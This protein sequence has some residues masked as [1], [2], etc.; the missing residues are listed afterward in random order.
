VA[1]WSGGSVADV[2]IEAS[3]DASFRLEE[4][5]AAELALASSARRRDG[6]RN[7]IPNS[8]GLLPRQVDDY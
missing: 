5:C 3:L 7:R 8:C 2:S 1:P 6:S 4:G